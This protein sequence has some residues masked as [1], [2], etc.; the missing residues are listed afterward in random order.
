[1]SDGKMVLTM[2]PSMMTNEMDIEMKM[3]PIQRLREVATILNSLEGTVPFASISAKA[4]QY[5]T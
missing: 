2:V 1:M 3:R 5:A 4:S